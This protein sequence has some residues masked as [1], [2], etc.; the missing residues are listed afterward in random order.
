MAKAAITTDEPGGRRAGC[1][2]VPA[3]PYSLNGPLCGPFFL[4]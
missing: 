4:E 3:K 2:P 1:I